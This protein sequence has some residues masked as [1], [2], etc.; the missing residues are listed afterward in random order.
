LFQ[1]IL[2]GGEE[3]ESNIKL[4]HNVSNIILEYNTLES[5]AKVIN[6]HGLHDLIGYVGR[7]VYSE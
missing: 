6:L 7:P 2:R 5:E 1:N 3:K 4:P